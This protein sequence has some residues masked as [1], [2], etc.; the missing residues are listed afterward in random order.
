MLMEAI[1]GMVLIL[2]ANFRNKLSLAQHL[3]DVEQSM[4]VRQSDKIAT[5]SPLKSRKSHSFCKWKFGALKWKK[6]I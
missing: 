6:N 4:K 5:N 1:A 2:S 3:R